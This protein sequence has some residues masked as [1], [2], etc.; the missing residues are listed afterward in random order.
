MNW[1]ERIES[2]LHRSHACIPDQ[3]RGGGDE[4]DNAALDGILVRLRDLEV[5]RGGLGLKPV[6]LDRVLEVDG[7]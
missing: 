4:L 2:L 1:T 6:P 5:G 7:R 3:V